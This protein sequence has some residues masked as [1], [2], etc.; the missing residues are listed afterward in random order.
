MCLKLAKLPK[1]SAVIMDMDGLVIDSEPTYRIAWQAAG[2]SLG[3]PLTESFCKNFAGRSF[4]VIETLLLEEFGNKFP[5]T[6][7]KH[8]SAKYWQSHVDK[9]GIK[10]KTGI[11]PL[12]E[13]LKNHQLPFCLATNS[14]K[15]YADKCLEYAGLSN[16]FTNMLTRDQ[17]RRPKPAPDIF[18]SA[19]ALLKTPPQQCVVLEDSEPGIAA[20]IQAQTIPIQVPDNSTVSS[21]PLSNTHMTVD[22]LNDVNR[23]II[24][25]MASIQGLSKQ[26]HLPS[27]EL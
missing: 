21:Q 4:D 5:L 14:E 7:F 2:H 16:T 8:Q 24:G 22:T 18:L 25:H 27:T 19:A 11:I 20:A 1:F 17:V 3:Y 6:Q 9:F 26:G 13:T 12:L 23:L 10:T 15:H